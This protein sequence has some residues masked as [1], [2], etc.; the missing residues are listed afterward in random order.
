MKIFNYKIKKDNEFILPDYLK[1]YKNSDFLTQMKAQFIYRI[2][3]AFSI[4]LAFLILSTFY[5]Q[6]FHYNGLEPFVISL[7]IICWL[8]S[9][10]SFVLI[11]RGNLNTAVH[12]LLLV[13]FAFIWFTIFHEADLNITGLDSIAFS[14]GVLSMTPLIADEKNKSVVFYTLL[15]ILA[16]YI[17]AFFVARYKLVST[18]EIIDYVVDNS[19]T[20]VFMAIIAYN[21]HVIYK[22]SIVRS[23]FALLS[24]QKAEKEVKILNEEL[25]QKVENRTNELHDALKTI[26]NSNSE[27]TL[28]N[29]KMSEEAH[30]L[31]TLNERLFE[32]EKKLQIANQTKDKM[33]SIIAHD[34]RNPFVALLNSSDLLLKYYD[35]MEEDKKISMIRSIKEASQTTHYLLENL[36][37]WSLKHRGTLQLTTELFPLFSLVEANIGLF[38]LS[39]KRK[40]IHFNN[41]VDHNLLITADKNLINTVIRNILSNAVK[42]SNENDIIT[43]EAIENDAF[44]TIIVSDTGVGMDTETIENLFGGQLS[45]AGTYGER[46]SGLGLPLCKEFIE[47]HNGEIWV[48]STPTVGSTFYFT[49]P[50]N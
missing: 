24:A 15:N 22:R 6:I 45:E 27:L 18:G 19:I 25:E 35:K 12:F 8:L 38:D 47:M 37:Q 1:A 7:E 5:L 23:E 2:Y 50:K 9:L 41:F 43:V 44:Y 28:L 26:E 42:F 21:I 4:F 14:F 29:E 10:Y 31:I 49:L 30:K 20:Y 34:L 17:F 36:L 11:K 32:S 13:S 3:I 48:E 40:K 16:L 39:A 33:F 46:G